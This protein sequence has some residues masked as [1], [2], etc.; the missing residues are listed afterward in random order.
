MLRRVITLFL[1]AICTVGLFMSSA[2]AKRFGGGKSFGVQRSSMSNYSTPRSQPAASAFNQPNRSG[3]SRWLGPLAGLA[4]GGLLASLFMGHG[5]GSGILSWLLVGGAILLI[6]SLFRKRFSSPLGQTAAPQNDTHSFFQSHAQ[7]QPQQS[8]PLFA[9]AATYN[10]PSGPLGFDAAT[11]LRDA[12]VQFI[13]LQAAYD[14]KNLADLRE[15]TSPEVFGEIQLQLQERGTA[16][17]V[18]EVV[19]LEA[20]L[21]QVENEPEIGIASGDSAI[22][23][24][25][26]FAGM[27]KEDANQPAS[28]FNEIWHFRKDRG[29]RG[30]VVTGIQQN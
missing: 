15:F 29:S 8:A 30:W 24:S 22:V 9:N 28:A 17:N 3:M 27:I 6:M 19:S 23:A 10:A 12:K 4:I 11:F 14:Q 20:D 2:E 18:T 7:Q 5:L 21:L 1:V 13:R 25:V 26:T 16:T